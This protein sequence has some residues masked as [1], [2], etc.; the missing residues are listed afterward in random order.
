MTQ[1]NLQVLSAFGCGA[2]AN[3]PS[4]IAECFRAVLSEDPFVGRF[5]HV[6]FAIYGM[7]DLFAVIAYAALLG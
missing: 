2:Y 7:N 5:N 3:P 6:V 4:S 1:V